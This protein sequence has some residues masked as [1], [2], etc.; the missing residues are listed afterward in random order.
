M[1]GKELIVCVSKREFT[2]VLLD[3]E[4]ITNYFYDAGKQTREQQFLMT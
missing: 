2:I 1:K 4:E 3:S